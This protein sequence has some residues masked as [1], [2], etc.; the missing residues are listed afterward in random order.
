MTGPVWIST[1]LTLKPKSA[2]VFSRILAFRWTSFSWAF[3][4]GRLALQQQVEAGQLVI[5]RTGARV[6]FHFFEHLR[7]FLR[8]ADPDAGAQRFPTVARGRRGVVLFVRFVH[9]LRL[10]PGILLVVVIFRR[11]PPGHADGRSG[12]LRLGVPGF[13][14]RAA[15]LDLLGVGRADVQHAAAEAAGRARRQPGQQPDQR[16]IG[17]EQQAADDHAQRDDVR[18]GWRSA[19]ATAICPSRQ[20][21]AGADD[22]AGRKAETGQGRHDRHSQQR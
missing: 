10:L 21:A 11:G 12:P 2:K 14:V 19:P 17:R 6:R 4:A 9:G 1:T 7:L 18:P 15:A 16:I 22:R 5:G 13:E 20:V 8:P 3:V